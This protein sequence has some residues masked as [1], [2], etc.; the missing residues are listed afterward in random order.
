MKKSLFN[1][2][3]FVFLAMLSIILPAY[4][5]LSGSAT[6]IP[7]VKAGA[8]FTAATPIIGFV[9]VAGFLAC[10]TS[11]VNSRRLQASSALIKTRDQVKS[12]SAF[13]SYSALARLL[14]GAVLMLALGLPDFAGLYVA[15]LVAVLCAVGLLERFYDKNTHKPFVVTDDGKTFISDAVVRSAKHD[16]TMGML[17]RANKARDVGFGDS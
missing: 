11:K 13:R 10:A 14:I 3:F 9:V 2:G 12:L 7:L 8:A 6:L 17:N 1:F 5:L 16:E 15:A 4:V